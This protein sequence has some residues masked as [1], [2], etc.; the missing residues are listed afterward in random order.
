MAGSYKLHNCLIKIT[1]T[2][3]THAP[4]DK[5][6]NIHIATYVCCLTYTMR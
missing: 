4:K 2:M 3:S 6:S 5:D 1:L